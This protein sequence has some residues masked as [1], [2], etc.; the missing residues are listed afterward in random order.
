MKK[1][2]LFICIIIAVGVMLCSCSLKK[3]ITDIS[4]SKNE[5]VLTVGDSEKIDAVTM[6]DDAKT[7]GLTWSSSDSDIAVADDGVIKAKS[8][9]RA[10]ITVKAENGVSE[11][12]NVT[13]N[14]KE[15]EAIV[16]DATTAVVKKG[17]KIQLTAKVR[18]SDAPDDS[19]EWKTAD[20]SIAEVNSEGFVTGISEGKVNIICSSGNGKSAVCMV[21]VKADSRSSASKNKKPTEGSTES[22]KPSEKQVMAD[23]SGFIFY[24]SSQRKLD[25]SE[26]SAL[27]KEQIQ[28]AINE[29]YAR[30][31][32]V[33]KTKEYQK[34]Y[35]AMPWYSPNPNFSESDLNEIER[36]NINL[37]TKYR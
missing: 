5:I 28:Q 14:D 24:D 23:Y 8:K 13:V 11:T 19:L 4:L 6:P 37:L 30:N 32:Y 29:I 1:S 36:Y 31:G 27:P 17:E 2:A 15:I 21:T 33:F 20:S 3:E 34:Y 35:E 7:K 12:C 22:A 16:L 10:V 25:V 26:V 18:P 9:G